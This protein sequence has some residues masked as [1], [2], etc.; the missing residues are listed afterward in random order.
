MSVAD[1]GNF[2]CHLPNAGI[3]WRC[4]S[5]GA[6]RLCQFDSGGGEVRVDPRDIVAKGSD[7]RDRPI[8]RLCDRPLHRLTHSLIRCQRSILPCEERCLKRQSSEEKSKQFCLSSQNR[9]SAPPAF[10]NS[11]EKIALRLGAVEI[12]ALLPPDCEGILKSGTANS[13]HAPLPSPACRVGG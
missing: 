8:A 3:V 5:K 12:G 10:L 1:A 7:L 4:R 9:H 2:R 13:V 11:L 6:G